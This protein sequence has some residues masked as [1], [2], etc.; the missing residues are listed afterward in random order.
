MN[1]Q[2]WLQ[3]AKN[4]SSRLIKFDLDKTR[5]FLLPAIKNNSVLIFRRQQPACAPEMVIYWAIKSRE[6]CLLIKYCSCQYSVVHW[7]MSLNSVMFRSCFQAQLWKSA[8]KLLLAMQSLQTPLC[9]PGYKQSK[10]QTCHRECV[11]SLLCLL[12]GP[13]T[14]KAA[15]ASLGPTA[16]GSPFTD[17]MAAWALSMKCIVL[18]KDYNMK[19]YRCRHVKWSQLQSNA[20][21]RRQKQVW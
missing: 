9:Q 7:L 20:A 18:L 15:S 3:K 16:G 11:G 13:S 19:Q 2:L 1:S 14:S 6:T 17:L 8:L 5:L 10:R 21:L 12:P 4:N